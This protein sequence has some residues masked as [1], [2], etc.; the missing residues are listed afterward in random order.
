MMVAKISC[1]ID[2]KRKGFPV[3]RQLSLAMWSL[4]RVCR[5]VVVQIACLTRLAFHAQVLQWYGYLD[6]YC[7]FVRVYVEHECCFYTTTKKD[8]VLQDRW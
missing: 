8:F 3:E 5:R 7:L 4:V 1:Q 2:T 6:P